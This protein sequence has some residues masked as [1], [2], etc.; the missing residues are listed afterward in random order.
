[1]NTVPSFNKYIRRLQAL[2][3]AVRYP[4]LFR[5]SLQNVV[6]FLY[7]AGTSKKCSMS[8][9]PLDEIADGK[10]AITL[11]DFGVREGNVT[12]F[13]LMAIALLIANHKPK[14]LLEV[15]TFDG[16]TTLQMAL[17]TPPDAMFHTIDLPEGEAST[18][19]PILDEDMKYVQDQNKLTRKY[20][21]STVEHKVIQ[22]FGDSTVYDFANFTKTGLIDFCFIDG[23]HSYECVKSDTEN[24]LRILAPTGIIL[25]H[26]FTPNCPGVYQYLSELSTTRSLVHIAGTHLVAKL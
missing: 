24:V 19:L 13:E 10:D 26:D 1:M 20:E 21:G 12:S 11:Q 4:S 16:N 18:H 2:T 22:H 23:G 15:G 8:Q 14:R 3:Y 5:Q 17:N 6:S 9:K 25:W 7:A